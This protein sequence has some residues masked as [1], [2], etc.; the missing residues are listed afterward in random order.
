MEEAGERP[1][2]VERCTE[3]CSDP[4]R[5]TMNDNRDRI[6]VFGRGDGVAGSGVDHS[7]LA[8]RSGDVSAG[9]ARDFGDVEAA[10]VWAKSES[11]RGSWTNTVNSNPISIDGDSARRL[12]R[13]ESTR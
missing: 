4:S 12:W 8:N 2:G 1:N 5:G 3:D 6:D 7:E 13:D 9:L 10:A 11:G